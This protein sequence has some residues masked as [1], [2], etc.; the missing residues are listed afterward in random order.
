MKQPPFPEEANAAYSNATISYQL[1]ASIYV[2]LIVARPDES[3][4]T[5]AKKSVRFAA[6]LFKANGLETS[7]I[8]KRT[9]AKARRVR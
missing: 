8:N 1:V 2:A 4:E 6:T 5:L 3:P 7:P 9:N